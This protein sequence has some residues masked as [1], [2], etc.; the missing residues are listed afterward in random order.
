[1]Q[2]VRCPVFPGGQPETPPQEDAPDPLAGFTTKNKMYLT[3]HVILLPKDSCLD[4]NPNLGQRWGDFYF[5]G[6]LSPVY[7][8]L[9]VVWSNRPW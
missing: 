4:A 6:T 3:L 5:K 8:W 9:K 7:N 2:G 1:M